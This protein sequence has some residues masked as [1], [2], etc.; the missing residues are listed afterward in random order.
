MP[1]LNRYIIE[2]TTD[3]NKKIKKIITGNS[4]VDAANRYGKRI[5]FGKPLFVNFEIIQPLHVTNSTVLR[6]VQ[7]PGRTFEAY[8]SL[9]L[10]YKPGG[11]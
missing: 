9:A 6:V 3:T 10:Q 7:A 4:A 8:V 1:K 5:I 2:Y 11:K